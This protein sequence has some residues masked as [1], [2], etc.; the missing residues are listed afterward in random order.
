MVFSVLW[1]KI[2]SSDSSKTL[3]FYYLAPL[4][5]KT[6]VTSRCMQFNFGDKGPVWSESALPVT[7]KE[8]KGEVKKP[9]L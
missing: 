3:L 9:Q 7:G 5:N 8:G 4:Q 2:W 6:I 1:S